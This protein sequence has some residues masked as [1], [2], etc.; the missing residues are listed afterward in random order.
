MNAQSIL[1][2]L[3][4]ASGNAFAGIAVKATVAVILALA[5]LRAARNASAS[6]R[7][8]M[9]AATFALL[10]LL[11]IVASLAPVNV[12]AVPARTSPPAAKG[13]AVS[14]SRGLAAQ[15]ADPSPRRDLATPRPRNLVPVLYALYFAGVALSVSTLLAGVWRVSR[16]RRAARVSV[17]GTRLANEMARALGR[18]GGIEVAVSPDLAVPI[19]FGSAH[20]VILLPAATA[21]WSEEELCRAIRH[22]LE[23]IA[24][25]DWATQ[26]VSRLALAVYWPHPLVWML[27][28]RLRLEAERACDDAVI[29]AHTAAESY[30]EQLVSLAQRLVGRGSVPVLAMATRSNLGRRVEAIL[31]AGRRRAPLTRRGAAA[32]TTV[33]IACLFALAP[34]RI[35]SAPLANA[36]T[37]FESSDEADPLD[38]ALFNVAKK[39]DV[40]AI[41]TLLARGAKA[42]AAISGDGSPLIAAARGGHVEAMSILIEAGADVNLG[43]SGDGS[44]LIAAAQHGNLDAVRLLLDRGAKIDA[45]VEGDGNALIMASGAGHTAVMQLLLDRGADIEHVVPGDENPLIHASERG[46][47]EAVR[48]LIARGA[49]VNAR[50]WAE[51]GDDRRGE[52]RTPLSMARRGGHDE[53]VRVLLAAGAKS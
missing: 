36:E 29:R 40:P 2:F 35:I 33:A 49:N 27:W 32:A 22:E 23:H 46:A 45:G 26:I 25:G 19:T 34:F 39:G 5:L 11:P 20:P 30:A 41:R 43:V 1:E 31:D 8:L 14:Q 15:A 24:R 37:I 48:L 21:E 38:V 10:L 9:A 51:F 16:L 3:V 4:A 28:S 6:S 18:A 42:N 44:P 13:L 17:T 52:W 47:I 50:V 7:H 12:V 53:V